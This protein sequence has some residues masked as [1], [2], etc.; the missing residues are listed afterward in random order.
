MKD[1]ELSGIATSHRATQAALVHRAG[2]GSASRRECATG[3]V[4]AAVREAEGGAAW[5]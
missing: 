5:A 3:P 4:R 2:D 1:T